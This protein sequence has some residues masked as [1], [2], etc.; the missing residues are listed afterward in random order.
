MPGATVTRDDEYL[1]TQFAVPNPEKVQYIHEIEILY[2]EKVH[3]VLGRVLLPRSDFYDFV[4]IMIMRVC[5]MNMASLTAFCQTSHIPR[6]D[7]HY[8][9]LHYLIVIIDFIQKY[10][11]YRPNMSKP[12]LCC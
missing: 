5:S 7:H 12:A 11:L 10:H 4:K 8:H 3:H 9:F 6:K 2:D 1:A